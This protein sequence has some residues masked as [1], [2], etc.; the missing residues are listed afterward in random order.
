MAHDDLT[1]AESLGLTCRCEP[2]RCRPHQGRLRASG[3]IDSRVEIYSRKPGCQIG[4]VYV[5]A[6]NVGPVKVGFSRCVVSRLS[7]L[8]AVYGTLWLVRAVGMR[9]DVARQLERAVH[10]RLFE[11]GIAPPEWY[12]APP[13]FVSAVL[14][15]EM[16]RAELYRRFGGRLVGTNGNGK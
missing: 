14:D 1:K 13:Q 15:D 3:D 12:D 2:P 9:I 6:S 16:N 5:I 10:L 4:F 7:A 8:S 11:W